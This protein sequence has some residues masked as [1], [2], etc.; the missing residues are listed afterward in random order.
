MLEETSEESSFPNLGELEKEVRKKCNYCGKE[1]LGKPYIS[2]E[3][4]EY[5][6]E[7]CFRLFTED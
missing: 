6:E 1:I 4:N 7:Y 2:P 3:G 5:C